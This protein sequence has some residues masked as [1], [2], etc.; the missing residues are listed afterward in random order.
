STAGFTHH[1]IESVA[2]SRRRQVA[3]TRPSGVSA[4][5]PTRVY[6]TTASGPRSFSRLASLPLGTSSTPPIPCAT[7]SGR[8]PNSGKYSANLRARAHAAP[9]RGGKRYDRKRTDPSTTD[10]QHRPGIQLVIPRCADVPVRLLMAC[11]PS[12]ALESLTI[13][14]RLAWNLKSG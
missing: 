12:C 5:P 11:Q 1:P 6:R 3:A 4:A 9:P 13:S 8:H 7:T 10:P 2:A 14:A